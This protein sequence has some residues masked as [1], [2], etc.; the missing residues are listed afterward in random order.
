MKKIFLC[1]GIFLFLAA[2]KNNGSNKNSP[3]KTCVI[4][5]INELYSLYGSS[6]D[7]LY[8]KPFSESLFSPELK[9]IL[10][11]AVNTSKADIE[12]VKHSD[13]PDEKPLLFEGA[14]FS[15]LYEGYDS[16]KIKS[17]VINPSGTSADAEVTFEYTMS[18]PKVIWTD[19][20]HLIKSGLE[21]KIDNISFDSIGNSKDLK[22]SLKDFTRT[23]NSH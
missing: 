2:C 12:K 20:V 5:R 14:V 4:Q 11:E 15:S 10:E 13:H 18:Q 9:R 16:Y 21:W 19:K 22:A 7:A 17:V 8:N 23:Q 1:L 3:V 6:N